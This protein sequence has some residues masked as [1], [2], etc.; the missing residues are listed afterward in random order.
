MTAACVNRVSSNLSIR[1]ESHS[2]RPFGHTLFAPHLDKNPLRS[3]P[4]CHQPTAGTW[5][6]FSQWSFNLSRTQAGLEKCDFLN[7]VV[8]QQMATG[9]CRSLFGFSV[10]FEDE[11]T[12]QVQRQAPSPI[13]QSA[14][15][16]LGSPPGRSWTGQ[17]VFSLAS[18]CFPLGFQ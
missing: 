5:P 12:V 1:L 14:S 8:K 15:S 7:P 6:R 11:L 17:L 2:K 18:F 16:R 10:L 13:G 3:G 4:E 9:G